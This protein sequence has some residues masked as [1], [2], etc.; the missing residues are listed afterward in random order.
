MI[1]SDTTNL[2]LDT[3]ARLFRDKADL[4]TILHAKDPRWETAL[5]QAIEDN[6]FAQSATPDDLGGAGLG[7]KASLNL[8]RAAGNVALSVPLTETILANWM[9]GQAGLSAAAGKIAFGPTGALDRL[10]LS[11]SGLVSGKIARLPFAR[12]CAQLVALAHQGAQLVVVQID[13]AQARLTPIDSLSGDPLDLL[14]LHDAPVMAFAPAPANF[15]AQNPLMLG[16]AARAMQISGALE[17]MLRLTSTYVQDRPAFGKVLSKFQVVQQSVAQ[18][19][20][21][22]SVSL[23]T[24]ASAIDALDSFTTQ[25]RRFD[26]PELLLEVT[27]AKL[28]ASESARNGARIAHQMHGAIGVTEEHVLHRLS[29]R[30]LA[31]SAEYGANDDWAEQLGASISHLGGAGLWALLSTR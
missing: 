23:S 16:A 24:A 5:W 10:E 12:D 15:T 19:A 17:E 22:V 27:A 3:A 14:E 31:W 9:L 1:D 21:E 6:G 26:D 13:L 30:A 29:L 11:A 7:L 4:Q 2:V 8:L 20:G 25:G 28:R 18:F